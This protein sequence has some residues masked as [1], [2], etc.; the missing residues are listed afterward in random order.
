MAKRPTIID[1]AHHAGVSKSTVSLVLQNSPLVKKATR[2]RVEESMQA[3]NYV[4][5]RTAANLRG[6]EA[7]LIG[8]VIN[9]LRNPFFAEFAASAQMT[10]AEHGFATV[11]AN[12]DEDID[13]QAQVIASM[14]EHGVSALIISPAYGD[15]GAVFERIGRAGLPAL[16]VLRMASAD[17]ARFPFASLDYEA[18]SLEAA[19]HLVESG[20]QKIAFVGGLPDR[21]VTQERMAGYRAVLG[22]RQPITLL[23]RPT[24]AFGREAAL[25][26]SADRQGIDAVLCFND[27]VALGMMAGFAEAGIAVGRDIALIGF[28]DIEECA[29]AFPKLSSVHCDIGAFGR[30]AAATMLAWLETGERPPERHLSPVT[31]MVRETSGRKVI[32]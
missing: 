30:D 26:L 23:G 7:G 19:R 27:L 4:Y 14:V 15:E 3:L 2:T 12:T 17:T 10:F 6:A 9:D 20:A 25:R 21:A 1:V 13:I 22:D 28:D 24:R 29:L 18:G 5:N 31:L 8:L 16:Q 11:I 32:P